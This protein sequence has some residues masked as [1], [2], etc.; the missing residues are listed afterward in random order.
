MFFEEF[1]KTNGT[2]EREPKKKR[3]VPNV[4]G[5]IEKDISRCAANEKPQI[6]AVIRS[7]GIDSF[8]MILVWFC[9]KRDSS[10]SF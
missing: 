2:R 5:S 9:M 7:K 10:L 1:F 6:I 8:F 4:N 3:M